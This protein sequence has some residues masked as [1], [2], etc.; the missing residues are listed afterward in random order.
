MASD[1][2]TKVASQQS[3]KAYVDAAITAAK[4]AMLPVGSIVHLGVSTNPN[5]LYGFG[6]WARI[7]GKFIVGVD[8]GDSDF[9]LND[10]GGAKDVT[11]TT[12]EMPSHTHVQDAHTHTQN[13]H[14]HSWGPIGTSGG[15]G[16][17]RDAATAQ[18]SSGSP[19]TS[20]VAAVNQNTTATNQNTGGDGAHEN[21]PPYIAKYIWQRTA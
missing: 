14:S 20:S 21:L 3:I 8:D 10:T 9:D 16:R 19:A 2:A 18:S 1:S 11:L 12:A 4:V 7:E 17:A 13:A 15:A 5:T 6:T